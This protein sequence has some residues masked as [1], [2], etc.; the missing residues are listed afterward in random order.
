VVRGRHPIATSNKNDREQH[1]GA[2][3]AGPA[4][5]ALRSG[6]A[7][8]ALSESRVPRARLSATVALAVA[9]APAA[10]G[11]DSIEEAVATALRTN[12]QVSEAHANARA[13]KHDVRE[14]RG[15]FFPSVDVDG[16]I[17]RERSDIDQLAGTE[18]LTRRELGVTVRQLL[19]DGFGTI[20]EV[21]R[22]SALLESAS[23]RLE[24]TREAVAF[25][26]V[27]SYVEVL[28]SRRLVELARDNVRA[29]RDLLDKVQ[30]RVERGVARRADVQQGQ[31]RL[32]LARSTLTARERQ[33]REAR[34]RY[35]RVIGDYPGDLLQPPEPPALFLAAGEVD[36][37]RVRDHIEEGSAEAIAANPA[38]DAARAE[39][40]AASASIRGARAGYYPQ[41]DL[42]ASANRDDNIAGVEGVRNTEAILLVARWNL[43]RGGADSARERAAIDRHVAAQDA[44]ADTRR[45]VEEAVAVSVHGKATGEERLVYLRE[46]ADAARE[47]RD[48]YVSQH[49]L[50]RRSLL[51]LLDAENEL[52]IARSNLAA[53]RYEDIVNG[54]FLEAAKGLLVQSL[55]ITLSE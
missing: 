23:S 38:I 50:G 54:Y 43:F 25:R 10:A 47:T 39:V 28:L 35:R 13:A 11:A 55:G 31:S 37:A 32:A 14:A 9:L 33:L 40:E 44:A 19:F 41:L 4:A 6:F 12:P 7:M 53:G 18:T 16:N 30:L 8:G 51:D 27:N 26:A 24:D 36:E 49:A 52:F 17:G 1:A 22:R 29:H 45:A 46:H 42:E 2:G 15:G 21:D 34:E 3:P 5:G 48:S 20:A